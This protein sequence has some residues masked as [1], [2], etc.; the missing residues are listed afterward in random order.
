[1]SKKKSS[2]DPNKKWT[3]FGAHYKTSQ[4]F[5]STTWPGVD[6]LYKEVFERYYANFLTR[7]ITF[8]VH[9]VL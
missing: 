9:R 3:L 4:A 2:A 6:F 7:K 1:M 5:E 8:T